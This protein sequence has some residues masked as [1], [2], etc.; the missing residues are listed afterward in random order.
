MTTYV[1]YMVAYRRGWGHGIGVPDTGQT[2]MHV[3]P[4][5]GTNDRVPSTVSDKL[6][7]PTPYNLC[8]CIMWD[9]HVQ[10]Y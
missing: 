5:S 4:G 1:L 9:K 10:M 2:H 3:N 7:F 8:T 6:L